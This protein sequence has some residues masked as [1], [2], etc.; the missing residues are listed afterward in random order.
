MTRTISVG[1]VPAMI[2]TLEPL[3][4]LRLIQL[5]KQRFDILSFCQHTC[6]KHLTFS[7]TKQQIY[8]SFVKAKNK[9]EA[10]VELKSQ[11]KHRILYIV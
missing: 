7:K 1:N 11:Y 5:S 2:K 4:S 9:L 10:K 8:K 6:L 3:Y